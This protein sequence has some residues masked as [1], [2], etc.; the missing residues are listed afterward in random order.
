[1]RTAYECAPLP[2]FTHRPPSCSFVVCRLVS[3]PTEGQLQSQS[4][5]PPNT[6]F[7][8]TDSLKG[9][10]LV[11]QAHWQLPG[12]AVGRAV[13]L[14]GL[15]VSLGSQAAAAAGSSQAAHSSSSSLALLGTF[16][17]S[18]IYPPSSVS[19]SLQAFKLPAAGSDGSADAALA[20]SKRC[21]YVPLGKLNP[22]PVTVVGYSFGTFD[23]AVSVSFEV[24]RGK[25]AKWHSS[26]QA[27][28]VVSTPGEGVV[29]LQQ[30]FQVRRTHTGLAS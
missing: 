11:L 12:S 6:A 3:I 15:S 13:T 16:V 1:M 8:T 18:G 28:H 27:V 20:C 24:Q 30:P 14:P 7:A 21:T 4:L 23:R 26:G 9:R 19:G 22:R 10:V 29:Q 25:W 17:G 5:S 2:L